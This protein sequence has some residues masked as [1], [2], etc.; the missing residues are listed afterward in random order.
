MRFP[1]IEFI[2]EYAKERKCKAREEILHIF[3]M[4]N[5]PTNILEET[6]S[7][8]RTNAYVGLHFHPDRLNKNNQSVV[9]SLISTG[10]YKNQFET[11]IS[12][13]LLSP[14]LG[15]MRDQW[16]NDFF[17]NI[18]NT[19]AIDSSER[20]KY[21]SLDLMRS[22]NG[23]SP[24][25][26]SCFFLLRPSIKNNCTFSFGDSYKKPKE[27]GSNHFFEDIFAALMTESFERNFA[28][29][30]KK[31]HPQDL[32]HHLQKNLSLP[33]LDFETLPMIKNLD[34]YIET[35]IHS[36]ISLL[37]DVEI[38]VA[39]P[40]FRQTI[41]EEQFKTLCKKYEI[42]LQWHKGYQ[43]KVKEVPDNFRGPAMQV[44]AK[45]IAKDDLINPKIIGD[46]TKGLRTHSKDWEKFG[47]YKT[48]LQS[49]KLLYHVIVKYGESFDQK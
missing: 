16:E 41:I 36:P 25:F 24:R 8:I 38:L 28:L 43:L 19:L 29:G 11:K 3:L 4:S 15:G 6:L 33:Y 26:G 7:S 22:G 14:E 48:C 2:N 31:M 44:L 10:Q 1:A 12:N 23:P 20:P 40:S 13:G 45:M 35:Q 37:K 5:I 49:L 21:G 30:F 34:H 27:K 17:G 46:A 39:D 18:Y 47:D 9:T 42:D 32:I